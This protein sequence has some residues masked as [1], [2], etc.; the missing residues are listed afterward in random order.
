[1]SKPTRTDA[2]TILGDYELLEQ[3]GAGGAGTVYRGLHR[4][5]AQVVAIKVL[6]EHLARQEVLLRRFEQEFRAAS[7]L[8]HPNIVRAL[9][10][11]NEP[12]TPF[13]VL[14]YVEGLSL[15]ERI[16]REGALPEDEAVH[17]ILQVC[18]GLRHAHAQGIIHRDVKPDNI[19]VTPQGVARLTDLGLVKELLSS[20]EL[21]RTGRGLGTP[22]FMAPEQFR[23][24][25]GVDVR[26]DIYGLGATLY[27]MVTGELPFGNCSPLE[28][29]QKKTQNRL[30]PPRSLAPRLSEQVE[31]VILRAMA[32]A[33]KNRPVSCAAF[34]LELNRPST[35][36]EP[37]PEEDTL[38]LLYSSREGHPYILRQSVETVRAWLRAG[39]LNNAVN[40]R[41]CRVLNGATQPLNCFPEFADLPMPP[42]VSP[43]V[44]APTQPAPPPAAAEANVQHSSAWM[45]V[46]AM[47]LAAVAAGFWMFRQ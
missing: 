44:D 19:L 42:V 17:L 33:P 46:V 22:H 26:C 39:L 6:P 13:L 21:T 23:D 10:F 5:T 2:P 20:Q 18:E 24:A 3:I 37:V 25:R 34:A 11:Q 31:R 47:A 40:V 38:Y 45:W 16:E 14:E 36:L 43:P 27:A 7:R 4:G 35:Q 8:D 29:Y 15:G 9:H 30:K 1:M 41:A 12:P 28:C 32:V